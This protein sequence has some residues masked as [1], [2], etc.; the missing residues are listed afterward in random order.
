MELGLHLSGSHGGAPARPRWPHRQ[1]W[2]EDRVRPPPGSAPA[3]PR[4][5]PWR[6]ALAPGWQGGA[7]KGINVN[8]Q[9]TDGNYDR[10]TIVLHW[11]T[12]TLVAVLWITGQTADYFPR[13]PWR[14]NV[15]SIHIVLGFVLALVLGA[16]LAWRFGPGR[17]LPAADPGALHAVAKATHYL[18]Y[19]L[20]LVVVGLGVANAIVRG[21]DL[22]GIA[23]LPQL[24][25][26]EWRRPINDWHDLAANAVL[27]LALFHAAA[28][29]AHHYLWRDGL[30]QR[31]A[32]RGRSSS[33]S[34]G[35]GR[36][37]SE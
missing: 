21:Y 31:M 4:Y 30:L 28:A 32:Y 3:Q 19:V 13:G 34:V 10:V 25:D 12:A 23:K 16:R 35:V 1:P 26:A 18:L 11:A 6:S 5:A 17:A 7:Y 37:T 9:R 36:V 27:A 8:A 15:W 22:F 33:S 29:L 2:T 24:G 14:L 20:L